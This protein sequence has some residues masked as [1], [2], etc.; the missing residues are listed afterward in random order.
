MQFTG[1]VITTFMSSLMSRIIQSISLPNSALLIDFMRILMPKII[2]EVVS[3]QDAYIPGFKVSPYST[4][5]TSISPKP[6]ASV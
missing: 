6:V 3:V 4:P 1:Y 5:R 2:L